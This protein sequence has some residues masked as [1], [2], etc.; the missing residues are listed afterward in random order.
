[1]L[2]LRT[3]RITDVFH[4]SESLGHRSHQTV[5]PARFTLPTVKNVLLSH[6]K[7]Q[8]RRNGTEI[9]HNS[10]FLLQTSVCKLILHQES[11]ATFTWTESYNENTSP[12]KIMIRSL[13]ITAVKKPLNLTFTQSWLADLNVC[14]LNITLKGHDC[15]RAISLQGALEIWGH[16][17]K[18]IMY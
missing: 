2:S 14:T 17:I 18:K 7:R 10:P 3:R 13:I 8:T 11:L 16:K 6:N 5:I 12:G 1:M 4:M 9:E 15:V